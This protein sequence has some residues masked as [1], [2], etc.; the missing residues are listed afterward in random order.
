MRQCFSK[1]SISTTL[2]LVR[3]GK[4]WAAFQDYSV[5]NSETRAQQSV[6]LSPPGDPAAQQRLRTATM[7]TGDEK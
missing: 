7:K 5:R 4:P 1:C 2:E 6:S 3:N